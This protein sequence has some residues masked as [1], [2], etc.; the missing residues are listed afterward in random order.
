MGITD[1]FRKISSW[2][3]E[4]I[5]QFIDSTSPDEYTL[6]DVRQPGEYEDGHLPGARL[7]PVGELADRSGELDPEK[8]AIVYCA[9]GV[10]S[11]AAAS[12]LNRSGFSKVYSMEGGIRAWQGLVAEGFPESG[13]NW[14]SAA[15]SIDELI[16]LAWLLEE[17]TR[18]FYAKISTACGDAEAADLYR[19]LAVAEEHHKQTL[20]NLKQDISEKTADAD[21]STALRR[22]P[23]K[24]VME[25][26]MLL[27]DALAWA[28]GKAVKEILEL[29]VSLETMSYDRYLAMQERII[30]ERSLKIFR[31]LA[32]EEKIHLGRLTGI[33]ARLSSVPR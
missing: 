18:A 2:T 15:H 32:A 33:L 31:M 26:G 1:Y 4:Q 9:S 27:D 3:P 24:K 16:A 8:T 25:G 14:F 17:G 22:R 21:L 23:Q 19:E 5:R 20:V 10:R 28:E 12:V 29:A 6:I 7:I 30:D 11:H 13:M